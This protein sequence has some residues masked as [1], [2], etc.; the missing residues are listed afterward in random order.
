MP[1]PGRDARS[2]HSPEGP[3]SSRWQSRSEGQGGSQPHDRFPRAHEATGRPR[4]TPRRGERRGQLGSTDPDAASSRTVPGT[5][6]RDGERRT[7]AA[8]ARDLVRPGLDLA[9]AV[10]RGRRRRRHGARLGPRADRPEH[11]PPRRCSR[12]HQRPLHRDA[13]HRPPWLHV[14]AV[15]RPFVRAVRSPAAAGLRGGVLMAQP[16]R[17]LRTDRSEP[18]RRVQGAR[19]TNDPV[20]GP[21]GGVARR[22]VRPGAPDLPARPG[23]HHP[24]PHG[25]GGHDAGPAHPQGHPGRARGGH[26]GDA[27]HPDPVPVPD[28]AGALGRP[29]HR[30][31]LRRR[32]PRRRRQRLHVL[33]VLDALHPG[34]AAGRHALVDREPGSR[35]ERR[36]ACWATRSRHRRAS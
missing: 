22:D 32:A 1:A 34:P 26:Q 20:V 14:P 13:A 24:R 19:P 15:L 35:W 10:V 6:L 7:G 31:L 28:P 33:V 5:I 2:Q 36:N 29:G 12:P 21:R 8:H 25:G 17:G 27:R 4:G 3:R 16:R 18:A 23:Q 11:L 30:H 9:G